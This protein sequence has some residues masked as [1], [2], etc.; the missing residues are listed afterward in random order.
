M[1]S[2][3]NSAS[4]STPKPGQP[5]VSLC[6][7][8][9]D[10]EELL[11]GCL[12][13]VQGVVAEIVA[14]DTG[15]VDNTIAIAKAF[16]ARVIRHPWND[17]FSEA[18]NIGLAHATGDW[19]MVMDADEELVQ[20]DTPALTTAIERGQY[21]FCNMTIVDFVDSR[22]AFQS[23]RLWRNHP[24][25][26]YQGRVHERP[27]NVSDPKLLG[28]LDVR[29]RHYGTRKELAGAKNQ[30]DLELLKKEASA[31]P[32]DFRL[33]FLLAREYEK[34]GQL[35]E[36]AA[37]YRL[38]SDQSPA[39]HAPAVS[40]N[41]A[42]CLID[43]DRFPE[44]ATVLRKARQKSPKY[45]DLSY[46]LGV[47]YLKEHKYEEARQELAK[48]LRL[49]DVPY[50]F[51]GWPGAGSFLAW[52]Q[53]GLSL[54]AQNQKRAAIDAFSRALKSNPRDRAS[55]KHLGELLLTGL[56][57]HEVRARLETLA[58]AGDPEIQTFLEEILP[59]EATIQDDP[60]SER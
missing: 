58:D 42:R 3:E 22:N 39:L 43:L 26:R 47:V 32:K 21:D 5:Q 19:I 15:S 44:A 53:I 45:T 16:G 56:P 29:I 52:Q 14:V 1:S 59:G 51:F 9:R 24:T 50:Q 48:C 37:E 20:E 30:R 54:A 28:S 18:R 11:A 57:P 2:Q 27:V 7:I 8:V 36:A 25:R 12:N 60:S 41:L 40:R 35:I 23:V 55:L 13:S 34:N 4:K 46:L 17:D 6:M 10:E 49:G 31:R 38:A 33:A